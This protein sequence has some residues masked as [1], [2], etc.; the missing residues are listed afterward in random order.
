[1][2]SIQEQEDDHLSPSKSRAKQLNQED[3]AES[4][5]DEQPEVD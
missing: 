3:L 5:N 2:N 1:L 4:F